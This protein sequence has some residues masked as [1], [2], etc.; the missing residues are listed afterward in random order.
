MGLNGSNITRYLLYRKSCRKCYPPAT[1]GNRRWGKIG[2]SEAKLQS[3]TVAHVKSYCYVLVW[4]CAS[5]SWL[6][7][8]STYL[9]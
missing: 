6:T 9:F 2:L 1:S 7:T 5:N 4:Y 8:W 3:V